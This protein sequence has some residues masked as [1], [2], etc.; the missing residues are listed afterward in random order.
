MKHVLFLAWQYLK[1]HRVKTVF[2]LFAIS[3]TFFIPM[4]LN[5]LSQK[6]SEKLRARAVSTPLLLGNKGSATELC[7]GSLYFREPNIEPIPYSS[8][9]DLRQQGLARAIPLQLE[10]RVKQQ[11]IVG[12]T[13]DYFS[14]RKLSFEQGRPMA[15]LGECVLG[16]KAAQ[17]LN[18]EVGSSVI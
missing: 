15:I 11:P 1:Y 5:Q 3:L 8:L 18:A 12:T 17:A 4:A 9:E 14:F 7:L 6:G 10:Y 16:S 2:L 13:Q